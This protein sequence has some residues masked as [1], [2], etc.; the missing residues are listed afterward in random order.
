MRSKSVVWMPTLLDR[1]N[2]ARTSAPPRHFFCFLVRVMKMK[3]TLLTISDA[4]GISLMNNRL[5]VRNNRDK[6][7]CLITRRRRNLR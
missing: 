5:L 3:F 2:P 1:V 7:S 6:Y 4:F